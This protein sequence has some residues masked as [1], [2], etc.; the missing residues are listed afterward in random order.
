M[1]AAGGVISSNTYILEKE[2]MWDGI[3]VEPNPK[4]RAFEELQ[5]NRECI[6][7]N[8]CIFDKEG[9]VDF[10]A[11]GRRIESSGIY[12]HQASDTILA[13]VGGGHPLI[14]V[15]CITLEQLLDKHN[16]PKT[17]DYLNIDTEGSEWDIL[18]VFDFSKYTFLTMT[19]E[20]NFNPDE[21][22]ER[23]KE[24]RDKIRKLLAD[25][26]YIWKRELWFGEDWFVHKSVEE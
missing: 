22:V 16:A 24:K 21:P 10:M 12:Y 5:K 20:N 15:P 4:L 8:L 13:K 14:K 7:E 25:N 1:G 6:C 26:G 2:F 23:N 18:R 9:E 19:I 17:I 3:C 11:R